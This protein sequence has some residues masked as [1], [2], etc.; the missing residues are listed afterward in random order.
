MPNQIQVVKNLRNACKP[1]GMLSMAE[2]D[3]GL[4][5]SWPPMPSMFSAF[6]RLG[7][8]KGADLIV[9]R[10]ILALSLEAGFTMDHVRQV[11]MCGSISYR[12]QDK[13]GVLRGFSE[14]FRDLWRDDEL[15]RR[16]G[17]ADVELG[18]I[19]RELEDWSRVEGAMISFPSVIVTVEK[20]RR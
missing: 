10:K 9:G 6:S 15:L 3:A 11:S 7:T 13:V 14:M 2:G 1:G 18:T 4:F 5:F 20:T 16:V 19:L 12:S 8:G 17:V